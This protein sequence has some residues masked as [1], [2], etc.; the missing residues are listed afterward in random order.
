MKLSPIL[1]KL[2]DAIF[3]DPTGN[4]Q[5]PEASTI[6]ILMAAG[7]AGLF[8][9]EPTYSLHESLTSKALRW[10]L[11]AGVYGAGTEI[12]RRQ[13]TENIFQQVI[14]GA[15]TGA[16]VRA[17]GLHASAALSYVF[18][19]M[20]KIVRH[21][22]GGSAPRPPSSIT[23]SGLQD[24]IIEEAFFRG[25]LQNVLEVIFLRL[26]TS[27]EDKWKAEKLST[28]LAGTLF[29]LAHLAVPKPSLHQ[30]ACAF[31]GGLVLG[32][33]YRKHGLLAAI[34]AHAAVNLMNFTPTEL[35]DYAS[36]ALGKALS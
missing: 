17:T 21:G 26:W 36:E 29:A 14:L 11:Y 22:T 25:V 23:N 27:K 32:E 13:H 10:T 34:S 33:V 18:F 6:K 16:L 1:Q 20:D 30:V 12:I 24:A 35:F 15:G 7:C 8:Y 31:Y 2:K 4:E 28:L 5:K 19:D 3:T 9:Q